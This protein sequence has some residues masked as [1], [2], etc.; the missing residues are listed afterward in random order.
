MFGFLFFPKLALNLL[1][2]SVWIPEP[3]DSTSQVLELQACTTMPAL[4]SVLKR[5][6]NM[7][8]EAES[9]VEML[10]SPLILSIILLYPG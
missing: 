3:P 10:R 8:W 6:L 2:S 5:L 4:L 9:L 7:W 1:G